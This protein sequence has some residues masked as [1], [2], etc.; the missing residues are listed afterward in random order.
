MKKTL[1]RY[2]LELISLGDKNYK[3]NECFTD[4]Y[5]TSGLIIGSSNVDQKNK[6]VNKKDSNSFDKLNLSINPLSRDKLWKNKVKI[7]V[8]NNDSLDVKIL[9]Q[10]DNILFKK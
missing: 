5:K 9:T 6:S 10:W 2:G 8:I 7:E 3:N 4:F 1:S